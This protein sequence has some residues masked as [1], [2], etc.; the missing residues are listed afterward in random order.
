MT[1]LLIMLAL[2]VGLSIMSSDKAGRAAARKRL[3]RY[4]PIFAAA[5]AIGWLMLAAI[6][7]GPRR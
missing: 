4:N 2:V 7:F 1:V 3:A 6:M 5:A